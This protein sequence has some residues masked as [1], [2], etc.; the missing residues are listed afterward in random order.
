VGGFEGWGMKSAHYPPW[1]DAALPGGALEARF[2]D[3]HRQM[4]A[5]M[6]AGDVRLSQFG[7][8][9]SA[10]VDELMWRHY[11]VFWSSDYAAANTACREKNLAEC[12]VC[13]GLTIFFALN[14]ISPAASP[15]KAYLYD[16]WAPMRGEHLLPSEKS[17][18]GSYAYLDIENTRRNLS[19]FGDQVVLNKG[20]I[21]EVFAASANPDKLI[22]LQID[23]NSSK[24]TVESLEFF[25]DRIEPGGV[26]LFNSY[27]WAGYE[28]TRTA[29]RSWCEGRGG[30]LLPLPTGQAIFFKI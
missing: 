16:S 10:R 25:F 20:F 8:K 15:S 5:A 13:D 27:A 2:L 24:P 6:A 23:L 14:A 30:R 11:V 28:D 29:V 1:V 4:Q 12:G 18:T 19:R 26:V 3:V 9:A 21:P 22:W 17:I 7:K